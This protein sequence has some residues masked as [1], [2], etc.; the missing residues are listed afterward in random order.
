MTS[1]SHPTDLAEILQQC[2]HHLQ[3]GSKDRRSGFHFPVVSTVDLSG[4]PRGRVVILRESNAEQRFLRFNADLRTEKWPELT[5]QPAI[6]LTLYD[7]KERVQLRVEG[8]ASLHSGDEVSKS[9]WQNSQRMSRIGYGSVPGPGAQL[10]T[11]ND[12]VLPTSDEEIELG[13]KNFGT[14]VVYVETMEWLYLK[15][16]GNCRAM[17]DLRV[18]SAQ[19]LA[20]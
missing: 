5:K 16:G 15:A 3:Q 2:W 14:I 8:T 20:P 12:Y 1:D 13:I 4:K 6:S 7:E 17:F 19:W 18:H 9:A 10:R 11:A